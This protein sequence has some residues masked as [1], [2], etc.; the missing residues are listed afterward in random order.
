VG[1]LN[2]RKAEEVMENLYAVAKAL[3]GFIQGHSDLVHWTTSILAGGAALFILSLYVVLPQQR[4][5][6]FFGLAFAV[7]TIQYLIYIPQ[8]HLAHALQTKPPGI[9]DLEIVLRWVAALCSIANNLLFLAAARELRDKR[10]AIPSWMLIPAAISLLRVYDAPW[11]GL[12]DAIFSGY[13]FGEVGYALA[14]NLS[15]RPRGIATLT[16]ITGIFYLLLQV[17]FGFNPLLAQSRIG[18]IPS[19]VA[20]LEFLNH[21]DKA[22]V[23]PLKFVFFLSGFVLLMRSLFILTAGDVQK[24]LRQILDGRSEYLA[25]DGILKSIGEAVRADVV[26]LFVKLPGNEK[27][28][29]AWFQWAHRVQPKAEPK[30]V[31]MPSGQDSIEGWVLLERVGRFPS[32]GSPGRFF[33][34]RDEMGLIKDVMSTDGSVLTV[35]VPV[36][37]HGAIIGCLKIEWRI[38]GLLGLQRLRRKIA[39]SPTLRTTVTSAVARLADLISPSVQS[40]REVAAL[41]SFG[42]RFA[43]L[44]VRSAASDIESAVDTITENLHDVL[45]PIE[46]RV[47][48]DIGFGRFTKLRSS[49]AHR[50]GGA[51]VDEVPPPLRSALS[52][53][54]W[55]NERE[56]EFTIGRLLLTVAPGQDEVGRPA[57]ATNERYRQAV[58]SLVSSAVLDCARDL[59]SSIL[60]NLGVRLS[61]ESTFG[62]D[63]WAEA[64]DKAA[65]E[66]NL[67]WAVTKQPGR[68]PMLGSEI[69]KAVINS[70]LPAEHENPQESPRYWLIDPPI[71]ELHGVIE[72]RL[73]NTG[74]QLWLGVA[75]DQFGPELE[76]PSPWKLF[77]EHMAEIAD[78]A[79]VRVTAAVEMEN[80]MAEAARYQGLA[81]VAVT[82]D[83]IAHHVVN[84]AIDV[85]GPT[86]LLLEAYRTG[87]LKCDGD[88]GRLVKL[89]SESAHG[90]WELTSNLT[91]VTKLDKRR[92]CSLYEAAEKSRDLFELSLT[93]HGIKLL[94]K[95]PREIEVDIFFYVVAHAINNLVSNAKD[96][97]AN[98]AKGG[99]I[100]I[101]ADDAGELVR[102]YVLDDGP[103]I[104]DDIKNHVFE[105]GVTTKAGSG[106]WGM[107]LV[108]RSLKENRASIQLNDTG[109]HG[110]TFTLC[111]PKERKV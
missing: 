14:V 25:N 101:S 70:R 3:V 77:I 34:H 4:W 16:I 87:D 31:P 74:A 81:T 94:N 63:G 104:P 29:M 37:Y 93:K 21:L 53:R 82:T 75:R 78:A 85:T 69:G 51:E 76:F 72:I 79:L 73:Q 68:A 24:M 42:S 62:L 11:S 15:F 107:Y 44:Q 27:N 5:A 43:R 36:H 100:V 40:F 103:G 46:T 28:L 38:V 55:Q 65:G 50:D 89:L 84:L 86:D 71:E 49:T 57:L 95:V 58:A 41:N 26:E 23:L 61:S 64:L 60:K 32:V 106:G 109:D 39:P 17:Q 99:R 45:S 90:L 98:S 9:N 111:F 1:T 6:K 88:Y 19:Y 18:D 54:I 59:F 108:S 91:N 92:P 13:C 80:V 67:L 66:A 97:I 110:T 30:M 47:E 83:T 102:C 105:L 7:F 52:V 96:A 35:G 33:P 56:R 2:R 10:P 22:F 48:V 12:P 20:R 8:E